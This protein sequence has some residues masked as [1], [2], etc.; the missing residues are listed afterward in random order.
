MKE[1]IA[2]DYSILKWLNA[3]TNPKAFKRAFLLSLSIFIFVF[4]TEY[5]MTLGA[6]RVVLEEVELSK[7]SN[8]EAV[9]QKVSVVENY[10]G[11]P[12]LIIEKR[13]NI[14]AS[15]MKAFLMSL[16]AFLYVVTRKTKTDAHEIVDPI[17]G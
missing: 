9:Y 12:V 3:Q 8:Y 4:L 14:I 10:Y 11:K 16:V 6:Q 1:D 13:I 17:K 7:Q 5:L 2:E 15:F